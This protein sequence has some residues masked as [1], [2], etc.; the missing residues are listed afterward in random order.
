[1]VHHNMEVFILPHIDAGGDVRTWRN[2]VDFDPLQSYNGFS[3]EQLM[4]GTIAD[5]L[6]ESI[7][8]ATHVELAL[9]GE[10]GPSLFRYPESYRKI[11]RGLRDR[12]NLKQLKIGISLNHDG[13]AGRGNPNGAADI[14]L[15]DDQR[16]Q[17][18]SLVN[19]CDFVGM[20]FYRPVS[21]PPR[22]ADFVRGIDHFM[23]EFR[24]H[25]LS[26]PMG[27][28]LHFSEVGIGGGHD[29]DDVASDPAKAVMSPWA[30]SGDP[31]VNP[32]RSPEMRQLRRQYHDALL[33]FLTQQPAR[34]RVSA[35]FFWSTG[36]WDPQGIRHAVFRDPAIAGEIDR[37]N[38]MAR[39]NEGA[40]SDGS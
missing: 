26:V 1:M 15:N 32:W 12:A 33:E 35:A 17:L 38:R 11:V 25:G 16:A 2:W 24:D 39:G 36:S 20:S 37:H 4:I 18:Q 27:T 34:W 21:V 9:S 19:E 31:R 14:Q 28:P 3:Y 6:A 5:A 23:E 7:R 10:M 29:D 13:I 30:G 8:P 22:V 40:R